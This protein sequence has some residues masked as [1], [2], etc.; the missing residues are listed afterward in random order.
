MSLLPERPLLIS[1]QLA[2]TLG[3]EE[4]LLYQLLGD[5]QHYAPSEIRNGYAW[6]EIPCRDLADHLPFWTVQDVRRI[7]DNLRDK[8]VLL[9]GSAPFGSDQGFRFAL[10]TKG[11]TSPAK[12]I[13][14]PQ[15]ASR[16]ISPQWQP[17]KDIVAQLN[18]YGIPDPFIHQQVAEFVSYWAERG[19]PQHSWNAKFLKQVLRLWR[20]EETRNARQQQEQPIS[21][22]WQPSADALEILTRQAGIHPNFVEDAIPEFILYWRERG[23]RK[24]TWNSDFVWHVRR[25]WARYTASVEHDSEPRVIESNWQPSPELY[26]VLQL[27]N[28]PRDFARQ[29]IPEFVLYWRETG[30]ALGSWNTKFLQH[31]KRQWARHGAAGENQNERRNQPEQSV[32]TRH[33]SLVEDLSDRS[34]AN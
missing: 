18:Q 16:L 5:I 6:T 9:I 26:E 17:A 10:I 30:Q 19:E 28:I 20:E 4:A 11:S 25:Q 27:A 3:L 24:R 1:P 22:D 8:G 21:A 32:S 13:H 29:Q 23:D 12:P 31:V 7:S 33:R 2:A 14:S 15:P 34:W